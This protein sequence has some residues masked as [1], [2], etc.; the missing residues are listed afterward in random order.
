MIKILVTVVTSVLSLS[1][2]GQNLEPKNQLSQQEYLHKS[3]NQKTVATIL[4]IGGAAMMVTGLV[5]IGSESEASYFPG[6]QVGTPILIAGAAVTTAGIIFFSASN[7]NKQKANGSNVALNL[8]FENAQV[9]NPIGRRNNFYPA[10]SFKL[11]LK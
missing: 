9:F 1:T 4:T 2:F 6:K 11:A 7:K 3:K 10:L 8:K 5:M